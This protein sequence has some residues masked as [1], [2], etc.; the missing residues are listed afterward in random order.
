MNSIPCGIIL[1]PNSALV[2]KTI[3]L[4]GYLENYDSLFTLKE[5]VY[6]PHISLYMAQ[7]KQN[8]L[9]R[10]KAILAD[11]AVTA[12]LKSCRYTL[13]SITRLYRR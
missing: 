4:S 8:E 2:Q 6:F 10:V 7:L 12:P 5:D 13:L 1:L 9:E 3:A 11:I